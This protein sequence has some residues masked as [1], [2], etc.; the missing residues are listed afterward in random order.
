MASVLR[1][2]VEGWSEAVFAI[3]FVL[4]HHL[5][6]HN[7][8]KIQVVQV[9]APLHLFVWGCVLLAAVLLVDTPPVTSQ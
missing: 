3:L 1:H 7:F 9:C 2:T 6:V 5:W 4:V 8:Q